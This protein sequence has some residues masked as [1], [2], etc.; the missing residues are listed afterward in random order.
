MQCL[1]NINFNNF[2]MTPNK[3]WRVLHEKDKITISIENGF[4][5]PHQTWQPPTE[6]ETLQATN[7]QPWL[8]S[9]KTTCSR[10]AERTRK[11]VLDSNSSTVLSML[12][13]FSLHALICFN[14]GQET[15]IC[16]LQAALQNIGTIWPYSQ[17]KHRLA[18][19]VSWLLAG[20]KCWPIGE[21]QSA[22]SLFRWFQSG[23]EIWGDSACLKQ[24]PPF[25][26]CLH[27]RVQVLLVKEL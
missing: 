27:A 16:L 18:R 14:L 11:T 3:F 20:P 15:L 13:Q 24:G 7:L 9:G 23:V 5:K 1:W 17:G 19:Y 8:L 25:D 22:T 4:T 26:Y 2:V 21:I 12:L 10:V 6:E